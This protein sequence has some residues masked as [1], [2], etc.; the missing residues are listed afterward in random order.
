MGIYERK[1]RKEIKEWEKEIL[2]TS[3]Y[4]S[5]IAKR[6]QNRFNRL[7]PNK[8]HKAITETIKMMVQVVLFGSELVTGQPL[9][10]MNL[11]DREKKVQDKLDQYKTV[12]M[13][14]GWGTGAGGIFLGL[15]DFPILLTIKMKFLFEIASLYGFDIREYKERLFILHVFQLAFSTQSC[16]KEIYQKINNWDEYSKTLPYSK[17]QFDWR[18]FQQEYRDYI[19]FAKMLQLLPGIGAVVG[20]YANVKLIKQLGVTAMNAY[21]LRI[22]SDLDL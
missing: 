4:S 5:K 8:V 3:N 1:I 21:R 19:D 22:L 14:S 20:A 10:G 12:A 9:R 13:A 11:E 18:S 7:I 17:D 6:I 16:R 15:A 2:K